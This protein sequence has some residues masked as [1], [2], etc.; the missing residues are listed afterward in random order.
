MH[1]PLALSLSSHPYQLSDLLYLIGNAESTTEVLPS[2][3]LAWIDLDIQ[4]DGPPE[5]LDEI[6]TAETPITPWLRSGSIGKDA[7]DALEYW[8]KARALAEKFG[9][10]AGDSGLVINGRVSLL[11]CCIAIL[12][13]FRRMPCKLQLLIIMSSSGLDR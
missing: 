7:T 5:S 11:H 12:I 9:M 6:L 1:N 3:L 8:T 10:N 13:S 4:L 2:E